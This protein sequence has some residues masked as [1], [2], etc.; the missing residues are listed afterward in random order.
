VTTLK[1]RIHFFNVEFLGEDQQGNEIPVDAPRV[2]RH[3]SRLPAVAYAP[4]TPSRYLP[5]ED[6]EM[7]IQVERDTQAKVEGLFSLKRSQGIPRIERLGSYRGL[8]LQRGEGLAEARHFVY[9]RRT[10]ILGIEI[11]GRGPSISAIRDFIV[12][13]CEDVGVTNVRLAFRLSSDQFDVLDRTTRISSATVSVFRDRIDEI[14]ALDANLHDGFKAIERSVKA[15]EI[16]VE[17]RLGDRRRDA[18]LEIPWRDRLGAF[19]QDPERREA[20]SKLKMKIRDEDA[21]RMR[22]IDFLEDRFVGYEEV[23]ALDDRVI[24]SASMYAAIA[25]SAQQVP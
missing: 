24:D 5:Y 20:V 6:D 4:G 1:R 22:E 15:L 11:N 9:F 19:L 14:S 23:V 18:T 17:L 13:K 7:F 16:G 21:G 25:R 12:A 2:F 10:G 8:G 3:L